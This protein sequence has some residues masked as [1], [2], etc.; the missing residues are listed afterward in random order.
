MSRECGVAI[1]DY[2]FG[3]EIS[4]RSANT[5]RDLIVERSQAGLPPFDD[6]S[7]PALPALPA[8]DWNQ[9]SYTLEEAAVLRKWREDFRA[10]DAVTGLRSSISEMLSAQRRLELATSGVLPECS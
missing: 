1:R 6:P 5:V 3:V 10:W 8:V 9:E 2:Q 7:F 4:T